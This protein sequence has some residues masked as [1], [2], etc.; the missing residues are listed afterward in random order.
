MEPLGQALR[1]ALRLLVA[2]RGLTAVAVLSLAVGIGANTTIFTFVD[3]LLLQPPAL[4]P[5][6]PDLPVRRPPPPQAARRRRPGGAARNL[7]AQHAPRQ[8]DRQPHA[9]VVSR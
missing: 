6:A 8:R 3:A 1:Y 7:A 4:R 9:A 2:S 5:P